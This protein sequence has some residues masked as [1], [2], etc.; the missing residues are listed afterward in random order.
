MNA[1][2]ARERD[3]ALFAHGHVLRVLAARWLGLSAGAGQHFLLDTGTLNVLG[4]H[5]TSFEL[6]AQVAQ[7]VVAQSFAPLGNQAGEV[8]VERGA[9]GE[10][11]DFVAA[12]S[13]HDARTRLEAGGFDVAFVDNAFITA[14]VAARDARR[15]P[16]L[17]QQALSARHQ[18]AAQ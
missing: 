9:C 7:D 14:D 5:P 15:L 13:A 1:V 16:F 6:R 4:S 3:Q 10:A 8:G 18:R 2:G 12:E 11:L 17:Q